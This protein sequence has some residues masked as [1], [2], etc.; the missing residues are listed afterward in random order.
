MNRKSNDTPSGP[1]LAADTPATRNA[2]ETPAGRPT[3]RPSPHR[4]PGL[5]SKRRMLAATGAAVLAGSVLVTRITAFADPPAT[6]TTAA[7]RPAACE[8]QNPAQPQPPTQEPVPTSVSTVEQAYYCIFGNY[9]GGSRLDDRPLLQY[10]FQAV[11]KEL[12][13]RGLDQPDAVL[14]ALTGDRG[15]DW[16]RFAGR[17]QTVLSALPVSSPAVGSDGGQT[18]RSSLALAA[19]QGMLAALHDNHA[20]YVSPGTTG[21][22]TAGAPTWGLG[23]SLNMTS[24]PAETAPD[25]T[26]PLFLT[27]V[28]SGTPAAAAGLKPGDVVES[29]DGVPV[30]T[31]GKLNPGVV[32]LLHPAYPQ[33]TSVTITLRRPVTGR[34]RHVR[35]VPGALPSQPQPQVDAHLINGS[36]ADIRFTAFYPGVAEDVLKAV[37]GLQ[38]TTPTKITGVVLDVRGNHGGVAQEGNVLLGA[39][40]HGATVVSF[41]DADGA[42]VPQRVD[43]STPLLHLPLVTL[44]DDGCASAC[45]VFATGVKDLDLGALIGTRTAGVNAGPALLYALNDGSMIRMPS[46][47]VIGANGELIDGVGV[48][49]DHYAPLTAADLSAGRDPALIKAA[50]LL[51]Q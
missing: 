3:H 25:F 26:G 35:L 10:A 4:R 45:E 49:P 16:S 48:P 34:T 2:P 37:A 50:S 30:F 1:A 8:R 19:I 40:V 6:A 22:P 20:G 51:T 38:A 12:R 28:G 36:I 46:Q 17:L 39:F 24:P 11:V 14:P 41:C 7:D 27:A 18:L 31:G 29:V 33:R 47:H 15:E 5:T 32:D 42:C 44:T 9:Y 13:K 23:I 43:D 21:S